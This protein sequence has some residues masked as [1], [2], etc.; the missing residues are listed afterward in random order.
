VSLGS[1]H[2]GHD[3]ADKKSFFALKNYP[4]AGAAG[5]NV[6]WPREDRGA[7]TGGTLQLY[8]PSQGETDGAEISFHRNLLGVS[9]YSPA[10]GNDLLNTTPD[11]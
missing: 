7:A 5:F 1:D 11:E 4:A 3:C 6:K 10:G 2:V 9:Q 8:T